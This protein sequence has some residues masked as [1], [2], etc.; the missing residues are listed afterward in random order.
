MYAPNA[1]QQLGFVGVMIPRECAGLR[2]GHVVR[3]IILKQIGRISGAKA[4]ILQIT[5]L[6]IA[7]ETSTS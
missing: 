3:T 1:Q 5:H 6:G 4:N 7:K 2:M